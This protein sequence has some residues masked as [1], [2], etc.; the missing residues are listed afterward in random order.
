MFGD[1]GDTSVPLPGDVSVAPDRVPPNAALPGHL[2]LRHPVAAAPLAEQEEVTTLSPLPPPP[3]LPHP[4]SHE[5]GKPRSHAGIASA[6]TGLCGPGPPG[7]GHPRHRHRHSG[8]A[9][10]PGAGL[11][12]PRTGPGRHPANATHT[13]TRTSGGPA[14]GR[15]SHGPVPD[16]RGHGVLG[17]HR[18]CLN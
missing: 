12:S 14:G 4:A 11:A 13:R 9:P 2:A 18:T 8:P 6:A 7:R 1:T 3:L 10:A 16:R 15:D 5:P 17:H